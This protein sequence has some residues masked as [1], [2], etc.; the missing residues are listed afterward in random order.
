M[1]NALANS[2]VTFDVNGVPLSLSMVIGMPKRGITSFDS[3]F[4]TVFA[5]SLAH[6]KTSG[7]FE[8]LLTIVNMYFRFPTVGI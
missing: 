8:N 2:L 3:I 4:T 1:D 7:H 5:S 6:A